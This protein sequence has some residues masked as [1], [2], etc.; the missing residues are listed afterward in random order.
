[1]TTN[2]DD[3]DWLIV[4]NVDEDD[5]CNWGIDVILVKVSIFLYFS[6]D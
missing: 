4:L 1:M 2:S 3:D 6:L 5:R